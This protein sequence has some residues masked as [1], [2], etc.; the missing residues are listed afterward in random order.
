MTAFVPY[1]IKK[2][3]PNTNPAKAS[4]PPLTRDERIAKN[5]KIPFSV[6]F[7]INCSTDEFNELNINLNEGQSNLCKD[8]RRRGKNK[9]N[10]ILMIPEKY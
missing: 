8:I 4:K 2:V 1:R 6:D 5:L 3:S 10:K 7:I 9:V